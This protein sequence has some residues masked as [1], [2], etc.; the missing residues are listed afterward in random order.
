MLKKINKLKLKLKNILSKEDI[1]D[2]AENISGYLKERRNNFRSSSSLVLTPNTTEEVSKILNICNKLN[3]EVITLSGNT[4]LVGG[5]IS[6]E[7]QIILS[8]K[9]LTQIKE[10]DIFNQTITVEGGVTLK[11]II[12]ICE[13]NNLLFP[14]DL[15]SREEAL[16]GGNLATNAGGLNTIKYGQIKNF[17]LGIEAVLANGKV[18]S[19]L[20]KLTKRNIGPDYKN[21]FIGSEGI[22]GVIT[23]ATLKLQPKPKEVI[24]ALFSVTSIGLLVTCFLKIKELF[25]L[26]LSAFE[27]MNNA[28]INVSLEQFPNN[29][30]PIEKKYGW[31]GLFSIDF[32]NTSTNSLQ[33]VIKVLK[34]LQNN[35]TIQQF[36]AL[37]NNKNIWEFRDKMSVAQSKK[38]SSIKHDIAIPIS[39]IECFLEDVANKI[40]SISS[41]AIPVIFGHIGDQSLHFNVMSTTNLDILTVKEQ[42]NNVV[43]TSVMG[44]NGNFS[45]EHGIGIIHKD[46]LK[47]YYFNNQFYMLKL[48]KQQ[49]DP[50]NI[51]NPNKVI[52]LYE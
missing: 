22:L 13:K 42:I 3:I 37:S 38:G 29:F 50:N 30:F 6:K 4:G 26:Q 23:A 31:Y 40:N 28:S 10:L 24:H 39:K 9:K 1:V 14:L 2:N 46:N 8:L 51:L 20:N 47:K 16:I 17:T 25:A 43:F 36:Y 49:L 34:E 11:R 19:D 27:I 48:L 5:G 52:S 45:A 33:Y 18:I 32:Y 12:D 21:L 41:E 15:P 44:Y 7:N 35:N